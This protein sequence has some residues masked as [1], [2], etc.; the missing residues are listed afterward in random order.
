MAMFA[1]IID[2]VVDNCIVAQSK[3]TAEEFT[4]H[5]CIEYT[6]ENP[7]APGWAYA[8][9]QFINPIPPAVPEI[10]PEEGE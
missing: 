7:A 10:P 3:E 2:G 5:T 6:H 8:D 1:V 9:G 4:G